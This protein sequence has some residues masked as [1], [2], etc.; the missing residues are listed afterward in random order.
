MPRGKKTRVT[1]KD[2]EVLSYVRWFWTAWGRGPTLREIADGFKWRAHGTAQAHINALLSVGELDR[3]RETWEL[4]TPG[5]SLVR[6]SL[7]RVVGANQDEWVPA[8]APGLVAWRAVQG[9]PISDAGDVLFV[10]MF[11]KTQRGATALLF[12]GGK[13]EIG[14]VKGRITRHQRPKRDQ[15]KAENGDAITILGPV[16]YVLRTLSKG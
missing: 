16:R 9:G 3:D 5:Q 10:D 7:A 1:A 8:P 12:V 13:Y 11:A 6:P 14:V 4:M 2:K 15:T